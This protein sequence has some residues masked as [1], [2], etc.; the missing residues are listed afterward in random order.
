MARKAS[1]IFFAPLFIAAMAIDLIWAEY[2]APIIQVTVAA[3]AAMMV[4]AAWGYL[5]H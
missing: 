5:T 1:M 3:V 4:G 2:R